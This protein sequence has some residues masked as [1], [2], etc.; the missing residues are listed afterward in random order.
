PLSPR[1][2]LF[3]YTT[4]FRSAINEHFDKILLEKILPENVAK[5]EV[6][7]YGA[8]YK[9]GL[10]MVLFATAFRLGIEP[11]FFSYSKNED[12][13]K[14]YARSEEHTSELQSRENLVC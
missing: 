3:P 6:G 1:S 11:F 12:A 10:F 9:L 5:H 4:L 13:P 2:R 8:C 7:V 14:T